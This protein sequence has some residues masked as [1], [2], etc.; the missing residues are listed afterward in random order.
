MPGTDRLPVEP[1]RAHLAALYPDDELTAARIGELVGVLESAVFKWNGKGLT[2][3][4]AREVAATLG[5]APA[6]IWGRAWAP[7]EKA[8]ATQAGYLDRIR[9]MTDEIES[10]QTTIQERAALAAEARSAGVPLVAIAAAAGI[11]HT[12]MLK[13][14]ATHAP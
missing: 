4:K 11:A 9:E 6:D 2:A 10:C 5:V 14:I 7:Y 13:Q 3:T 1:L 12:S 8:D